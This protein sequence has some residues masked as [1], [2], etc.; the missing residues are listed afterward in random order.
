MVSGLLRWI[1]Q[2]SDLEFDLGMGIPVDGRGDRGTE[3]VGEECGEVGDR[4]RFEPSFLVV[5]AEIDDRHDLAFT[6]FQA[7]DDVGVGFDADAP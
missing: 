5:G 1:H 2:R 7:G 4:L 6:S 3:A